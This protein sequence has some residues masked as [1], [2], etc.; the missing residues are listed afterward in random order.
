MRWRD[1]GI[2]PDQL[3][4]EDR[5]RAERE[6]PDHRSHLQASGAAVGQPQH[7]VE[8]AVLLVPHPGVL[9]GVDH[10][11]RDPEEVLEEL[12]AHVGVGRLRERE[13][14]GDLEHVLA[15]ER[16]P[17][18]AVGLLQVAAGRQRRAAVEDAD[19]VEPEKAALEGVAAGAVLAVHPPGEVQDQLLER[20][21]EPLDVALPAL[22]LLEAVGEDRGP[23]V[24]RRVHV[25]EVP[26]VRRDLPVRVQVAVLQ[27]QVE[28]PLAEVLVDEREREHVER[29]VPGRVPRVLPLVG[30]RD[31][32]GVRHVVPVVVA[33]GGAS[34]REG[35]GAVLDE[36]ACRRRSC[37]TASTT[38]C[39]RAPGA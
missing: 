36:P 23:G 39:R 1:L 7:V 10:R 11:R 18:G 35:I 21:L 12:Q 32:V 37:R 31:D 3:A 5:D 2:L 24:D 17:G 28:L 6:Q 4:L 27:H 8:E 14:H 20:A 34:R 25:A 9:A 33:R 30:H 16:H 13:L 38:A 15:E 29:Q 26:L 19:V 22:R